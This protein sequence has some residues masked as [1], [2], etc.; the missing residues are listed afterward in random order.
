MDLGELDTRAPVIVASL[1]AQPLHHIYH[2]GDPSVY[3][4]YFSWGMNGFGDADEIRYTISPRINPTD[5]V[6][7]EC[8]HRRRGDLGGILRYERCGKEKI[9]NLS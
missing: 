1:R 2:W 7:H 6:S 3:S 4:L 5:S 9:F 8:Q